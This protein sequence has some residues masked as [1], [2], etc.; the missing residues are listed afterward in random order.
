MTQPSGS[1]SIDSLQTIY[2]HANSIKNE[3][4]MPSF[5]DIEF[6][7][8]KEDFILS[9]CGTEVFIGSTKDKAIARKVH[10]FGHFDFDKFELAMSLCGRKFENLI[11]VGA[12]MGTICIPAIKRGF[13]GKAFA[14]EPEPLNFRHLMANI[15]LNDL[16]E[17]IKVFNCAV[18]AEDNQFLEF[19]LSESN[20]GDHRVKVSSA[21]GDWNESDRKTIMVPSDSLN[22]ILADLHEDDLKSTLVWIDTQG[23]EGIALKGASVILEKKC[24]L[25]VEFWP[26]GLKRANCYASF[27]EALVKN[28]TVFYDLRLKQPPAYSVSEQAIDILY[29]ELGEAN[30]NSNSDLLFL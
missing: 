5:R 28:Y 1:V 24:P 13:V 30:G 25:V 19:E 7:D 4:N 17:K 10:A 21:S 22:K 27:K 3:I 8:C 9:S 12:N 20:M 16:A 29:D 2:R 15:Y 6:Q 11:D 14:I 18:G 26:Y 23:Y